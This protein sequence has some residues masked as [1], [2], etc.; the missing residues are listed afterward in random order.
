MDAKAKRTL[1]I[2]SL[3]ELDDDALRAIN[4]GTGAQ[5]TPPPVHGFV[6][7]QPKTRS[8][9]LPWIGKVGH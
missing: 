9:G 1:E 5:G 6:T 3:L 2:E 8:W 4:G 7:H